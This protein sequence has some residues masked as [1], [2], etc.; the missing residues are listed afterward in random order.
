MQLDLFKDVENFEKERLTLTIFD[1]SAEPHLR[2]WIVAPW[3]RDKAAA[4]NEARK[5]NKFY[6]KRDDTL[7]RPGATGGNSSIIF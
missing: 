2:R 3:A 7:L 5:R 6:E 4:I 1:W